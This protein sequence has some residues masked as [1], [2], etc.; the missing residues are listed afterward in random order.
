[1]STANATTL[2]IRI[3]TAAV[4]LRKDGEVDA[5]E[6]ARVLHALAFRFAREGVTPQ[7]VWG[8]R[9]EAGGFKKTWVGYWVLHAGGEGE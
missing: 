3:D 5:W 6:I 2:E 1:M 4:P 7:G 9:I 8:G